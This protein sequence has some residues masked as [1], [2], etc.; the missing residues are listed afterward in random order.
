VLVPYSKLRKS[1]WSSKN[2][3]EVMKSNLEKILS[4]DA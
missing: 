2:L 3:A 4:T 1:A